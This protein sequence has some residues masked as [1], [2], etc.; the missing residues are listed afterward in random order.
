MIARVEIT[1]LPDIFDA[2]GAEVVHQ[3]RSIGLSG[4][5]AAG[6]TD[7]FFFGGDALTAADVDRLVRTLLLDP[8]VAS[9]TWSELPRSAAAF[10]GH[11][12]EVAPLPGTTDSQAESLLQAAQDLGVTALTEAATGRRVRLSGA[13]DATS[14]RRLAAGV[15]ANEVVEAFVI[16]GEIEAPFVHGT[17]VDLTVETIALR[18]LDDAGLAALSKERRLSLNVEELRAIQAGYVAEERDPTDAELEMFAQTWSEHCVHKT[19]KAHI[20]LDEDGVTSVVDSMFK[21]Y[22]Y[23]ATK[24]ADS[25]WLKSVFVDNAGIVGFV[26][27]WDL[28]FKAE[29]HNH[30]SALEPFGGSNTGVG[31]VIRDVLGV[32]ARPIACTDV[33][34]FGPPDTDPAS[35]PE[36]VLHP[37]R[38]ASGVVAGVGDYGNKMGIPTVNG[39]IL[40]HRGYTANPL[41]YCGCVGLLPTDSHKKTPVIGDHVVTLGGRTGRDGL[42]GATFSSMEMDTNTSQIAGSSVQIG[43]AIHEKQVME[44]L[45]QARDEG[46]YTAVTDCG[47]GGL[48]S[49]VGEMAEHLG[50]VIHLERVPLKY[51]GLRPWEIW[52]SEAQERMVLA[53]SPDKWDRFTEVCARWGVE[54]TSLGH[55]SGDGRL[56]LLHGDVVVANLAMSALHEGIPQRR[57]SATWTTPTLVEPELGALDVGGELLA[58]LATPDIRSKE[59]VV[60]TYDHEVQA[61][62][63]VKPFTGAY[64]SGPSDAAVLRPLEVVMATGSYAGRGVAISN[65]I[66]PA[67]GAV[68]PY[69]MAWAAV[70]EA[71]RN[72]VCV[73]ADPDQLAL[74]DNFCWG[75]PN[76]PDRLGGLVRCARGCY[77]AAVA[78]H[79]PYISGKDSLNNEYADENGV[80]HAIPGTLLISALA[81][82]P[83]VERTVT[84]DAKRAGDVV[85]VVGATNDELGGSALYGRHGQIGANV[86][87]VPDNA[88]QVARRMHAAITAG[89]VSAAHDASEGGLAVALAEVALAGDLGLDV[90]LAAAPG[91]AALS[92]VK[93]AFSESTT[94][95]VVTTSA[96]N[97]AA[98]AELLADLPVARIGAVT[99]ARSLVLRHGDAAVASV[100]VDAL[101]AA[102][103]GHV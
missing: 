38:I 30:P 4:F 28:A 95:Y 43:H 52:L 14:L 87:K 22:I 64:Q 57:L 32:S 29:T 89:L 82:V 25:P 73:G 20:T 70:D 50:A 58:L 9:A 1:P 47:A 83:E 17:P 12:I 6:V 3:A 67:Y 27:G 88:A 68:D 37:R 62:T 61:G 78:F 80:R 33:L 10:E 85:F 99:A 90:D 102:W 69:W 23:A 72:A 45:L 40:Y 93:A 26:D 96:A 15:L 92:A 103:R 84:M 75:N 16:D 34:C 44:A 54:G 13:H 60:R 98:F 97:A 42:R 21:T 79:A 11:V 66:N 100:G 39:A 81:I 51:S 41:V 86:P 5:E 49:A 71:V 91:A 101:T 48:S 2:R 59:D 76:L 19:F 46:L 35:L 7:L 31:G 24:L 65:G 53:V 36:G 56:K 74:L 55:F 94:R 8:V 77:D 63:V 18:G